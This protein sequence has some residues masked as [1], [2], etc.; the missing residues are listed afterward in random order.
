MYSG[1]MIDE[2]IASVERVEEESLRLE[3]RAIT[4]QFSFLLLPTKTDSELMVGAA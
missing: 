2:L 4:N 1:R 3:L